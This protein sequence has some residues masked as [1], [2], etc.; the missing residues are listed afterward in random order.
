MVKFSFF[1]MKCK[2][3]EIDINEIVT[4][5]KDPTKIMQN[6]IKAKQRILL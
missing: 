1:Y 3:K 2:I 6:R 4:I 5:S